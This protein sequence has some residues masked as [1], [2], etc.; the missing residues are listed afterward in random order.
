MKFNKIIILPLLLSFGCQQFIG[1]QKSTP[2]KVS[3]E[4]LI[5][6]DNVDN[7]L[8]VNTGSES[9]IPSKLKDISFW[10][11]NRGVAIGTTGVFLTLN[12]GINWRRLAVNKDIVV[13]EKPIDITWTSICMTSPDQFFL[14]GYVGKGTAKQIYL[15]KTNTLGLNWTR[16]YYSRLKYNK[17]VEL[18]S[19]IDDYNEQHTDKKNGSKKLQLADIIIDELGQNQ[20]IKECGINSYI[21]LGGVGQSFITN[22]SGTSWRPIVWDR[23]F[24]PTDLSF[25]GDVNYESGSVGYVV[26]NDFGSGIAYKTTDGGITWKQLDLPIGVGAIN[27]CHFITSLKGFIAGEEG[28]VYYTTD[29]GKTWQD[30]SIFSGDTISDIVV[31]QNGKGWLSISHKNNLEGGA[32]YYTN[33]FGEIWESELNGN[34]AIERIHSTLKGGVIGVGNIPGSLRDLVVIYD[35]KPNKEFIKAQHDMIEFDHI[36]LEDTERERLDIL[37]PVSRKLKRNKRTEFKELSKKN[38]EME[39]QKNGT[40]DRDVA[41]SGAIKDDK[42]MLAISN[43]GETKYFLTENNLKK[44]DSAWESTKKFFRRLFLLESTDPITKK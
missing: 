32:I 25:P 5:Q 43:K 13:G 10:S 9:L 26:G 15:Y 27:C 7:W 20:R 28:A 41:K 23:K 14:L 37:M 38:K 3:S 33:D 40:K 34:K 22:D 19:K 6:K 18:A 4:E 1:V 44:K 30:H 11:D 21:L 24:L 16:V 39:Q 42:F 35:P 8:V 2:E 31:H 29:G 12:G 17:R 36:Q